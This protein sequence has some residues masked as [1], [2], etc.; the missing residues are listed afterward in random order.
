MRGHDILVRKSLTFQLNNDTDTNFFTFNVKLFRANIRFSKNKEKYKLDGKV[1]TNMPER[2]LCHRCS[3]VLYKGDEPVP[4]EE[5]VKRYGNRC[6]RC[7]AKL[8]TNPIKIEIKI[9]EK[10]NEKRRFLR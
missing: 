5:I 9:K 3:F 1:I 8:S 7:L 2:I 10:A 6:P 4:P